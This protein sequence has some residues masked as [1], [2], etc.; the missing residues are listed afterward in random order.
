MASQSTAPWREAPAVFGGS[1]LRNFCDTGLRAIRSPFSTG[2]RGLSRWAQAEKVPTDQGQ[3][4]PSSYLRQ[5]QYTGHA[6]A[7][8]RFAKLARCLRVQVVRVKRNVSGVVG[9]FLILGKG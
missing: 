6:V 4:A 8:N 1:D 3:K 7:I 9:R 5:T 2:P